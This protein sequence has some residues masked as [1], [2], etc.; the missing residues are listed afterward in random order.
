MKTRNLLIAASFSSAFLLAVTGCHFERKLDEKV[1]DTINPI[2]PG[3]G[4]GAGTVMDEALC[5][6]RTADSLPAADEDYFRDM[7][8]GATKNPPAIAAALDPYIPGITPEQA[9]AAAVKGET[10]G[11]FGRAGTIAFGIIIAR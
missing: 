11:S 3:C 10:I 5:A 9:V 6:G 2:R 8:Y 4:H 1:V 7:D